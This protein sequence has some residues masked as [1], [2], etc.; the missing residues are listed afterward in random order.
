VLDVMGVR[1]AGWAITA[2][3]R[4]AP[5]AEHEGA[6][7][8]PG[9]EAGLPAEVECLAGAAEDGGDDAGVAGFPTRNDS[10]MALVA[11]PDDE[12]TETTVHF[13]PTDDVREMREVSPWT[14]EVT[15]RKP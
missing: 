15:H 2:R 14:D 13:L 8:R 6:A 12:N 3:E 4:A 1:P 9:D 11:I 10:S 7:Q 5:V